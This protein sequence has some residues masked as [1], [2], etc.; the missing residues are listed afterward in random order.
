[1]KPRTSSA[2]TFAF[3]LCAVAGSN[4]Y[5]YTVQKAQHY[6]P[7]AAKPATL[8]S[9]PNPSVSV[10]VKPKTA[11]STTKPVSAVKPVTVASSVRK[12]TENS[13]APSA[14]AFRKKID[15]ILQAG[16]SLKNFFQEVAKHY[17]V[18]AA[19]P[20]R[21]IAQDENER[22]EMRWATLFGVARISGKESVGLIRQF[23]KHSSWMLRDAALKTA[24]A[25]DARELKPE[26]EDKLNDDALVV[27]TT[28]VDTI[29]HMKMKDSAPKLVGALFDS[30]NYHRGKPLWIHHHIFGVLKTFRYEKAVPKLVELLE[31]RENEKF[32]GEIIQTL[33]DLTGKSFGKKPISQQIFL[34]KRNTLSE[35]TF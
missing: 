8:A 3:T 25:L 11:A 5:A 30:K 1:M 15:Q 29:G 22:E 27:R 32:Q 14:K 34:W 7:A 13:K 26:I 33:E 4:A 24:A 18:A 9:S 10:S 6:E 2:L 17:G 23:M 16:G 12:E 21:E 19:Q 20:L 35:V 31:T 28:A